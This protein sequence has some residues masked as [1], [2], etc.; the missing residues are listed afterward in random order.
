MNE[1]LWPQPQTFN[2]NRFID[3]DGKFFTSP[4]FIPFQTGKR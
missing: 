2:P 3:E 1:N 4:N